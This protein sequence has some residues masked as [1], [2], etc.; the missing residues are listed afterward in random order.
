MWFYIKCNL[1]YI[2]KLLTNKVFLFFAYSLVGLYVMALGIRVLGIDGYP[3]ARLID[4]IYGNAHNPYVS[5]ALV[6]IT[7]KGISSITPESVKTD[8][9]NKLNS[10]YPADKYLS[11]YQFQP[12]YLYEYF[13]AIFLMFC[14]LLGFMY[15]YQNILKEVFIAGE[16]FYYYTPLFTLLALPLI[17][18]YYVYI[19]DFPN[20]FFFTLMLYSM[21]KSNWK[22]FIPA[23]ALACLNKETGIMII[24]PFFLY[25]FN[26]VNLLEKKKFYFLGCLQLIVF[27]II[28][29]TLS[30][31]FRNNPGPFMEFHLIDHNLEI[32]FRPYMISEF[33]SLLFLVLLVLY[34]WKEKPEFFRKAIFM[35][36][37][38]LILGIFGGFIDEL[39]SYFFELFTIIALLITQS[40]FMIYGKPLKL[41]NDL[42][43]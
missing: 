23:F 42:S 30:I 16:L 4:M 43:I 9:R 41:K 1:E 19:Y 33:A 18:R 15:V 14:G 36:F 35:I 20:L 3:P 25:F 6:P 27:L 39:R 26:R 5:R 32:F 28:K 22:L 34:K 21:M 17:I 13:W 31:V 40:I 11:K 10:L 29:V 24:I 2:K 37:P 7:I 8:F 12:E 38:L